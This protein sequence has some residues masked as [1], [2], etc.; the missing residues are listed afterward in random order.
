MVRELNAVITGASSGIGKAIAIAIAA[1]GGAV[2]LVGRNQERLEAVANSARVNARSVSICQTDLSVDRGVEDLVRHVK[3]EFEPL[4]ALVHCA[5]IHAVG[6]LEDCPVD[7]LDSLYRVNVRA[8][9]ALT[10]SLLPLLKSRK[11]QIVFINS[12]QGLSARANAGAFASTQHAI[13]A[14]ADSLRQEVN[15]NGV[16]VVSIYS[17]RTATPRIEALHGVEGQI[18][19]PELLLQAEDIAQ[20]VVSTLQLPR[21]AEIT[22]VEIRSAIKS[23]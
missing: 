9:F 14:I 4:D 22:N 18:Y 20:V 8:P 21:T 19:R 13:K 11:G 15:V 17:G 6:S 3:R 16:R 1:A 2:C 23:Y 10:Q 7:Q 5:G 12:S